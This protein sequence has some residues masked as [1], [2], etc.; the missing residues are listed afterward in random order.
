V[1]DSNRVARLAREN[2]KDAALAVV[3]DALPCKSCH[4]LYRNEQKK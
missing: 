1:Q 4:D 2:G 3:L